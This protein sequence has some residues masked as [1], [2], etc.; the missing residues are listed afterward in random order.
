MKKHP[1]FP[2]DRIGEKK[3]FFFLFLQHSDTIQ[4][5]MLSYRWK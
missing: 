3:I 1:K 2:L 5:L 4:L